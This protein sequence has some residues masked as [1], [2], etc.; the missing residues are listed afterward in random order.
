MSCPFLL[1]TWSLAT[2]SSPIPLLLAKRGLC[3]SLL[4]V[5]ALLCLESHG[6]FAASRVVPSG[7]FLY[8]WQNR[9]CIQKADRIALQRTAIAGTFSSAGRF[10]VTRGKPRF[11]ATRTYLDVT[12][13][14]HPW[15]LH[16]VYVI[17]GSFRQL[18]LEREK[19]AI[20]FLV[21]AVLKNRKRYEAG[22][23]GDRA[24]GSPGS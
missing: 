8:H 16:L 14:R 10:F 19:E 2:R 21:K 13:K 15:D 11:E 6:A 5:M 4:L 18:L 3:A 23:E 17:N 22:V 1:N 20:A 9:L 24:G 7:D 12:P